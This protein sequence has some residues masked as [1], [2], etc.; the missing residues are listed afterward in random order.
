LLLVGRFRHHR[1]SK[2]VMRVRFPSPALF[3]RPPSPPLVR[4]GV[5]ARSLIRCPLQSIFRATAPFLRPDRTQSRITVPLTTVRSGHN[6]STRSAAPGPT[7]THWVRLPCPCGTFR[8]TCCRCLP[9]LLTNKAALTPAANPPSDPILHHSTS[10]DFQGRTMPTP[11]LAA[12]HR[13]ASALRCS[14]RQRTGR[15]VSVAYAS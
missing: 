12:T 11:S 2:L 4:P 13:A 1:P 14:P 8:L 15:P 6:R 3:A 7:L 10:F 5:L 9:C